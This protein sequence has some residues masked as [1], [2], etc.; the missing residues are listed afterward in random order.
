MTILLQPKDRWSIVLTI[1]ALV[2]LF[3][4]TFYAIFASGELQPWAEPAAIEQGRPVLTPS[5]M[6]Y[7]EE[8]SFNVNSK[9]IC[10]FSNLSAHTFH[11]FNPNYIPFRWLMKI[12]RD[13]FNRTIQGTVPPNMWPIIH[14][15]LVLLAMWWKKMYNQWQGMLIC[16]EPW[17]IEV[18]K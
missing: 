11:I 14:F 9:A 7:S 17:T 2:H 5:K 16:M 18:I 12:R 13:I 15:F 4:I 10:K 6:G 1:A 8:T 3:G